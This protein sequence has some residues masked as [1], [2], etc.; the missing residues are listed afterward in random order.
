MSSSRPTDGRKATPSQTLD[1][2]NASSYMLFTVV[3]VLVTVPTIAITQAKPDTA[4]VWMAV[5]SALLYVANFAGIMELF[6]REWFNPPPLVRLPRQTVVFGYEIPWRLVRLLDHYI[7]FSVAFS[8][9]L[10]TVWAY[11]PSP[12]KDTYYTF[13][14]GINST[15][16]WS[17]WNSL[18][19]LSI[20]ILAMTNGVG[21]L[22]IARELTVTL[23]GWQI[24][25]SAPINVAV[26][27]LVIT[28]GVELIAARRKE[29]EAAGANAQQQQALVPLLQ[30]DDSRSLVERT[31]TVLSRVLDVHL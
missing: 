5:A 9:V 4:R 15:N 26:V 20:A 31:D 2:P 10:L 18:L 24:F 3:T 14:V 27:A 13:A 11:D 7:G 19:L 16:I 21:E 6:W 1:E 28:R 12:T 8:L 23:C 30:A 29:L 17:A 25:I 22:I